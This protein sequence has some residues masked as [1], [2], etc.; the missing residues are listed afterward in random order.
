MYPLTYTSPVPK[1]EYL[2]GRFLAAFVL[3]ALILLAVPAGIVA[4]V[5]V[6]GEAG[7]LGPFQP[8]SYITA[9]GLI[10]LPNAF[11]VT[12]IQFSLAAMTGRAIASYLGSVLLFVTA[13]L[14][15]G[16]SLHVLDPIG[17]ITIA[18]F[19]KGWTPIEKNTRLMGL[20]GLLL[21]NR[22]RSRT[23]GGAVISRTHVSREP[24]C[25]PRPSRSTPRT[26]SWGKPMAKSICAGSS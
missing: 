10:A 26:R 4:A 17:V 9:Y 11:V 14:I 2:G 23:S 24:C 20:E 21:A 3:N 18:E 5:S 16:Q 19:L 25:S 12:A 22:T 6:Y 1:A 8:A 15:A 7:L 13:F